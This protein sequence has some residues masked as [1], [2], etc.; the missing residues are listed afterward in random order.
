MRKELIFAV[1]AL[2]FLSGCEN[3]NLFSWTHSAGSNKSVDALLADGINA[4]RNKDYDDAIKFFDDVLSKQP[5]NS[6]AL[7]GKASSEL[8]NAGLDIASLIPQLINQDTG[9]AEDLLSNI[10][11]GN[12]LLAT[13]EAGPALKKIA[14]G[15]A[16][17][18]IPS[19]DFDINLNLGIIYFLHAASLLSQDPGVSVKNN[20]T[21]D[22]TPT[23][24]TINKAIE[25]IDNAIKYLNAAMGGGLG[26]VKAN[27]E[28][29][30]TE[31]ETL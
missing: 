29:F 20:F 23:R 16:D 27:F 19:D 12:L 7:Y 10:L 6:E 8:K 25:N 21:V 15:R 17:G 24:A 5:G 1:S 18:A 2:I 9:A 30:K 11:A 13:E 14:D 26:G 22:G 28:S 4:E 3:G 31:L